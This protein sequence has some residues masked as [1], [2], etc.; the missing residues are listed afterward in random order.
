[1]YV[2]VYLNKESTP[3]DFILDTG[4]TDCII[5]ENVAKKLNLKKEAD[6][7]AKAQD[8][9]TAGRQTVAF[10]RVDKM[11][12]G[13]LYFTDL[14]IL[15][16]DLESLFK[17]IGAKVDGLI[18]QSVLQLMKT[19]IDYKKKKIVFSNDLSLSPKD[20]H[21][22]NLDNKMSFGIQID[23]TIS[24]LA[25]VDTGAGKSSMPIEMLEQ[26]GY[27]KEEIIKKTGVGTFVFGGA[28]PEGRGTFYTRVKSVKINDLELKN[29]VVEFDE[30][31]WN[32]FNIGNDILSCFVV[33]IVYKPERKFQFLLNEPLKTNIFSIGCGS[34]ITDK[35]I[36]VAV[37]FENSPAE[38]AGIKIGD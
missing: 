11:K 23:D 34:W 12:I 10:A 9:S 28:V 32:Q 20:G 2:K 19:T 30:R 4:C 26:L 37:I 21:I 33:R 17:P 6:L 29:V 31:G 3:Y 14:D 8:D 15:V 36:V 25:K 7:I 35:H 18:G 16:T 13:T 5:N 24:F 22:V 38:R 1:M 27:P